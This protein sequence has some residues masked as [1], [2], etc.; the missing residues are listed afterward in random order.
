[1]GV[2]F[3]FEY[4]PR[5][6]ATVKVVGFGLNGTYV[7]DR[8]NVSAG[9]TRVNY[10]TAAAGASNN[11]ITQTTQLTFAEGSY[12]GTVSFNYD[13]S[14]STLVNHRYLAFYNAQCCG[15]SFEYIAYN[16]GSGTALLI[17]QN[18]RFNM[19]FTLAGVGSFSNFFGAF[20]GGS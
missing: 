13:F 17:P 7:T 18:R 9:W 10:G 20:G 8:A 3:R 15:V 16:Y 12:G 19:S 1:M 14:R 11:Y 6:E 2:D 5:A 4:D